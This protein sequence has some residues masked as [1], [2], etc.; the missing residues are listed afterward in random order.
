[1][2]ILHFLAGYVNGENFKTPN[3]ISL[4]ALGISFH[5]LENESR[6]INYRI[7]LVEI[8]NLSPEEDSKALADDEDE[9]LEDL[10]NI[11]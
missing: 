10:T 2:L 8:K 5:T 3:G 7:N 1:L 6:K 4:I 9:D 11:I